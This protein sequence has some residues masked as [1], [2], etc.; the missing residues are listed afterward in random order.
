MSELRTKYKINDL[1]YRTRSE[2]GL[3]KGEVET[4]AKYAKSKAN[5]DAVLGVMRACEN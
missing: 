4:L 2:T 3:W 1:E 5:T